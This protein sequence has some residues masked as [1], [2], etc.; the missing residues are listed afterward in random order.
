MVDLLI[1]QVCQLNYLPRVLS[2]DDIINEKQI[3]NFENLENKIKIISPNYLFKKNIRYDLIFNSDSIT[4]NKY[5]NF[6][7]ENAKYF[8]SINHESNKNKVNHLFSKLNIT[9]FDRN[10]YWL[11]KGYLEEH[12]RFNL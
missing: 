2:E 5:V 4:Q 11:R 1:P 12:F 6:I 9:A 7:K 10:L 3:E 8:Y